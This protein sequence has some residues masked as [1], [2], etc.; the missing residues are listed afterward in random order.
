MKR[1]WKEARAEHVEG[2][3][4]VRLDTRPVRTPARQL[5]VVPVARMADGIAA[6]WNVQG[7]RI[8]PLSMPL[9]RA[10]ATCI[11]RVMPEIEAV[12]RNVAGYAGAD[13]LCYRAP[14]PAGLVRRQ[15]AG[16]DP[17]LDWAAKAL[18]A[19]KRAPAKV[20]RPS[21]CSSSPTCRSFAPCVTAGAFDP[22]SSRSRTAA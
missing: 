16:W 20:T 7:D 15:A 17:L 13:L 22:T 10:A 8:D 18:G 14:E 6:E 9:T 3:W 5:C 2:G 19:A 11:D 12:R 4:I 1:F 21:R